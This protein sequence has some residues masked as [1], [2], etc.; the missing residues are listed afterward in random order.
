[1]ALRTP[2]KDLSLNLAG[3]ED[4]NDDGVEVGVGMAHPGVRSWF[5][6]CELVIRRGIHEQAS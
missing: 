3:N 6:A 1:M 4:L 2:A 5:A